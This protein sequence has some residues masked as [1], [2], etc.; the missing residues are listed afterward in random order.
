MQLD[1]FPET[2]RLESIDPERNRARFY[3]MAVRE[4]LFG[5]WTLVRSWGRIGTWGRE[6]GEPFP[7]A[8]AAIDAMG[9]IAR[10]KARRGYRRGS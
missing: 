3:A 9:V 2:L 7:S 10:Q 6:A 8:G 4:D 1:L 5:S